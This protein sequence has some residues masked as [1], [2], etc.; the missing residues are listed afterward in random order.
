MMNREFLASMPQDDGEV[1]ASSDFNNNCDIC[2]GPEIYGGLPQIIDAEFWRIELNPNQQL[3]GR[4]FIGLKRHASTLGELTRDEILEY[5]DVATRL[6]IAARQA[7]G[8]SMINLMLLMNDSVDKN[9]E[10]HIHSHLIPR[11]EHPYTLGDHTYVD[12]NYGKHYNL[13]E[14][15]AYKPTPE[16]IVMITKMMQDHIS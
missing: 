4:S 16:E 10:P 9:Q 14:K 8:A 11:Y 15:S 1:P 3:I 13:S 7:F 2:R 6:D 12:V 5:H